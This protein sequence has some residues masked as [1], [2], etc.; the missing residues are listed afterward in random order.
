MT[1][2]STAVSEFFERHDTRKNIML[3]KTGTIMYRVFYTLDAWN[4][5]SSNWCFHCLN[6]TKPCNIHQVTIDKQQLK[7]LIHEANEGKVPL[8]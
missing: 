4:K 2:N 1:D 8:P 6:K 5:E 3:A 7:D